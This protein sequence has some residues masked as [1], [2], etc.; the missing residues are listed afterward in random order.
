MASDRFN[1]GSANT[2]SHATLA[3]LT[4][5]INWESEYGQLFEGPP[6]K[7][8]RKTM[9]DLKTYE[10][11]PEQWW[12]VQRML[13]SASIEQKIPLS[14]INTEKE[15]ADLKSFKEQLNLPDIT[16]SL[17]VKMYLTVCQPN[18]EN[19]LPCVDGVK[20]KYDTKQ[21]IREIRNES[22]FTETFGSQRF[23]IMH[24]LIN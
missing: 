23:H 8:M 17:L 19:L 21:K 16:A 4:G 7:S 1:F 5:S 18:Y 20:L 11:S 10:Y 3:L 6:P 2:S 24:R 14:K 13:S 9:S 12:E 15:F 22:S